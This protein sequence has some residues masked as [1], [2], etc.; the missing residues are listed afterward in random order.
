LHSVHLQIDP[1]ESVAIVGPSG[2][3]K[4]TLIDLLLGVT[5][6]SVGE[7]LIS[8]KKPKEAISASPGA[9]AY[10]PQEIVIIE[11]TI[12]ENIAL[13]FPIELATD[14]RIAAALEISQ[15]LALVA[16]LPLGFDSQVGDRGTRLSGGER[17]RLGIARALFSNPKLIVLDEASSS[18]DAQTEAALSNAIQ[19]LKGKVT[20]V[21]VAHRLSTVKQADQ[22][23]YL[24]SGRLV[25]RG[26]F[27][28]VRKI[29]PDFDKQAQLMGL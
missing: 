17:Q 20:V 13:G 9:I 4:T 14:E 5:S 22:V 25:M 11:G 10:V 21:M 27:E 12:R 23:I 19:G 2:A 8:G 26:T 16:A 3:G 6:S 1:G 7:I 24:E 29:V 18:L 28:E 15:R